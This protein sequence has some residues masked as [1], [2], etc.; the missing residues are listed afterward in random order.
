MHGREREVR[1][2]KK[3]KAQKKPLRHDRD[4]N[5]WTLSPEPSMLSIRP[6]RPAQASY[7][8]NACTIK[9]MEP[10]LEILRFLVALAAELY[11]NGS[12]RKV[13]NLFTQ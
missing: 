9:S 11:L 5:P 3:K 13:L 2:K 7:I 10:K 12:C 6:R 1:R 4:L 8:G